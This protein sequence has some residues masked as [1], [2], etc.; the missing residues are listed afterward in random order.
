MSPKESATELPAPP[1]E[2]GRGTRREKG[3]EERRKRGESLRA[4]ERGA[5]ATTTPARSPWSFNLLINS[6][7]FQSAADR[8]REEEEAALQQQPAGA[9]GRGERG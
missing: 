9:G 3:G 5:A 4:W 7:Y 2:R 1:S 6:A 8:G